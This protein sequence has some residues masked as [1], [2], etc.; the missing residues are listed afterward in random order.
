[1]SDDYTSVSVSDF[2]N[3]MLSKCE[4]CKTKTPVVLTGRYHH[5]RDT[6]EFIPLCAKCFRKEISNYT[7]EKDCL[8]CEKNFRCNIQESVFTSAEIIQFRKD[9]FPNLL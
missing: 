4:Y 2:K 5:N 6:V 3:L 8:L 7:L 1:M 9:F